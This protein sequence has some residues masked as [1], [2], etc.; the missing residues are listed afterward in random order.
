MSNKGKLGFW[1]KKRHKSLILV[2]AEIHVE[3][4]RISKK[5]EKCGISVEQTKPLKMVVCLK[6]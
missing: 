4:S 6:L 2:S 1:A 5:P 3:K